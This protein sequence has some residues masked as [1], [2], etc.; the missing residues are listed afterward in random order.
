MLLRNVKAQLKARYA[1]EGRAVAQ[2]DVEITDLRAQLAEACKEAQFSYEAAK[3]H[4]EEKVGLLGALRN[5]HKEVLRLRGNAREA[6]KMLEQKRGEHLACLDRFADEVKA[7]IAVHESKLRQLSIEYDEELYP[8]LMSS[9]AE[10]RY[11]IPRSFALM[12]RIICL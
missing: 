8:H 11:C 7:K 1:G 3:K 10:R 9:I 5:E 2:R 6:M 4:A 12:V